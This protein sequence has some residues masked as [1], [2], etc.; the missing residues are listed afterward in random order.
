M[1]LNP[2][3]WSLRQWKVGCQGHLDDEYPSLL[4]LSSCWHTS[5]RIVV[6]KLLA[7]PISLLLFSLYLI[8]WARDYKHWAY[9]PMHTVTERIKKSD[10]PVL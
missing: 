5:L 2:T 4:W 10:L 6:F 8:V 3:A 9:R 7:K 1:R